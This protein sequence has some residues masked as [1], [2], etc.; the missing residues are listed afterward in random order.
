M[1]ENKENYYL[2]FDLCISINIWKSIRQACFSLPKVLY[3]S[4]LMEPICSKLTIDRSL[5]YSMCVSKIQ[6]LC[7]DI[8]P[9]LG[10]EFH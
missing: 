2:G 8:E 1:L 5:K 4:F 6:N 9:M 10:N 7:L 3:I